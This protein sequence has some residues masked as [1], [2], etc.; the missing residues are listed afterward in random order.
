MMKYTTIVTGW[1]ALTYVYYTSEWLNKATEKKQKTQ[2]ALH[3]I[4]ENVSESILNLN[5]GITIR[6]RRKLAFKWS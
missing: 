1:I 5:V 4:A 3:C 2:Y 6:D